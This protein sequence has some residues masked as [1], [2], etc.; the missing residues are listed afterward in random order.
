M[1]RETSKYCACTHLK[2]EH[3]TTSRGVFRCDELIEGE[4]CGCREY[5]KSPL[6]CDFGDCEQFAIRNMDST[7]WFC[8]DHSGGHVRLV[9]DVTYI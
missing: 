1:M 9:H 5:V 7:K 3:R 4:P 6:A 8:P 2:G